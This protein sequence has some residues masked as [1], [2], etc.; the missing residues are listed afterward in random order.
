MITTGI[1][2]G[3][4]LASVPHALKPNLLPTVKVS[5]KA[6]FLGI[7]PLQLLSFHFLP[8]K[9]RVLAANLLDMIW[10]TMI[11]FVTH[12]DRH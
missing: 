5:W 4:H 8:M 12:R 1:L 6:S 7:A 10:V 2:E 9:L 11:S 3:R